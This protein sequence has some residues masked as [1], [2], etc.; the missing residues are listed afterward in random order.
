LIGAEKYGKY[1][2]ISAVPGN[3]YTLLGNVK[4][5]NFSKNNVSRNYQCNQTIEGT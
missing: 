2:I 4:F 1:L 3:K 5:S